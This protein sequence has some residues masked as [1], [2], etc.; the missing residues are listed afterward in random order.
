MS[1]I[2][3]VFHRIFQ[4]KMG[5]QTY[6]IA[7]F[8]RNLH[9]IAEEIGPR[10]R[11]HVPRHPLSPSSLLGYA[12][13]ELPVADPGFSLEAPTPKVD[14]LSYYFANFF[15]QKLQEDEIIWTPGEVLTLV[16][17]L[18]SANCSGTFKMRTFMLYVLSVYVCA[19]EHIVIFL[20]RLFLSV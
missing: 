19:S 11:G 12:T 9:K 8:L 7:H 20:V 16:P 13:G 18:V 2:A 14:V 15:C 3:T 10:L 1:S 5:T 4:P 17:S 6:Y